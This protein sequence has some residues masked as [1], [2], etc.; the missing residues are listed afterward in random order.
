MPKVPDVDSFTEFH[1]NTKNI[2]LRPVTRLTPLMRTEDEV[3]FALFYWK[4]LL[5]TIH[6]CQ[7]LLGN[8]QHWLG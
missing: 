2:S 1:N 5:P 6:T 3:R 7:L 4:S 8:S